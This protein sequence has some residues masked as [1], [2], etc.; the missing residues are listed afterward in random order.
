M[1]YNSVYRKVLCIRFLLTIN[2]FRI[3]YMEDSNE[4][5]SLGGT[6]K[7]RPS[8]QADGGDIELVN[9]SPEGKVSV[10]LTGACHGCPCPRSHSSRCRKFLKETVPEVTVVEAV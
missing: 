2:G 8:L 4:R 10:K 3:V 9:V 6:S 5:Q 7:I 1:P